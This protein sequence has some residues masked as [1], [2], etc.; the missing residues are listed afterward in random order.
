MIDAVEYI[1]QVIEVLVEQH[2]VR[3]E[4]GDN[5]PE[6]GIRCTHQQGAHSRYAGK[7]SC[8]INAVQVTDFVLSIFIG[9]RSQI[10][11]DLFDGHGFEVGKIL[12]DHDPRCAFGGVVEA[13]ADVAGLFGGHFVEDGLGFFRFQFGQSVDLFVGVHFVDNFG[14]NL[15]VQLAEYIGNQLVGKMLKQIGGQIGIHDSDQAE[16]LFA[17]GVTQMRERIGR[18]FGRKR[19]QVVVYTGGVIA[20][21]QRDELLVDAWCVLLLG[22]GSRSCSDDCVKRYG[23]PNYRAQ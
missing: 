2:L 10:I 5:V 20:M 13:L 14:C 12:C 21:D 16:E 7:Q 18:I 17:I 8:L 23:L 9:V 4:C 6:S 19:S 1:I 15:F 11:D 3:I 22:H